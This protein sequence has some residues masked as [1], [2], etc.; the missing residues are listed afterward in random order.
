[1]NSDSTHPASLDRI[2][3]DRGLIETW[4]AGGV[5]SPA[6]RVA[7]LE[8][9]YPHRQWG[10]WAS[11]LLLLIGAAL[12]LAG[13]IYFFAFNWAKLPAIGKFALIETALLITLAGAYVSNKPLSSSSLPTQLWLMAASV[14]VGV[15]LAVFGQIYQTG[16]DAWNLFAAWAVLILGWAWLAR[17]TGLWILW[18]MLLNL[19][20]ALW[21]EQSGHSRP[22]VGIMFLWQEDL[23]FSWLALLNGAALLLGETLIRRGLD[24]LDSR[25]ARLLLAVAVLG[26]LL[27]PSVS[28][29]L[30]PQHAY[31]GEV[32][33]A[34]LAV[35]AHLLILW[36]YSARRRDPAV[37]GAAVVSVCIILES[38]GIHWVSQAVGNHKYVEVF[39]LMS[40]YTIALFAAGL[41]V[42]HFL[43]L[44]TRPR[45]DE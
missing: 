12:M 8:L 41:K 44:A 15:F 3:A 20:L 16:A 4:H 13:V 35:P 18:L 36:Y 25:W 32:A 17:F 10:L 19:T 9:L 29:C 31:G 38:L 42:L 27:I 37:L 45:H 34:V 43:S 21:W 39:F 24:W 2:P 1:M 23:I 6:A 7:A 14:L 5:L 40:I 26:L 33:G 30:N 11:R 28:F 22:P